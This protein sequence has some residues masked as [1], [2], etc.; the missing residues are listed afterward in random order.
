MSFSF[1][2]NCFSYSSKAIGF[3]CVAISCLI[4]GTACH[5]L[6]ISDNPVK[7]KIG[8][9]AGILMIVAAISFAIAGIIVAVKDK[10]ISDVKGGEAGH[11]TEWVNEGN[12]R[13][14]RLER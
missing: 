1:G 13:R 11:W 10:S 8:V 9:V 4:A 2:G 14:K 6:R 7:F 12:E 3:F 5:G